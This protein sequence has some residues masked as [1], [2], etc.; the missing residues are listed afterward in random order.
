MLAAIT[1]SAWSYW[2]WEDPSRLVTRQEEPILEPQLEWELKEHV[3]NVVFICGQAILG[4]E[5]Y[6]YYGGAEMVIR[7]ASVKLEE[8]GNL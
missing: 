7:V 3:P 8:L 5:I 4:D 1:V 6:T 2:A